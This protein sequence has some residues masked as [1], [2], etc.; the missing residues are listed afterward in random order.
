MPKYPDT[1]KINPE[2]FILIDATKP[3]EKKFTVGRWKEILLMKKIKK[4][5]E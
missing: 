4:I 5:L 2:D 3:G 1:F